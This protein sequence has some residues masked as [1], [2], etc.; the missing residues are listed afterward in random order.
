VGAQG[1]GKTAFNLQLSNETFP[2]TYIPT[3]GVDFRI[4]YVK[5]GTKINKVAIWETSGQPRFETITTS[6]FRGAKLFIIM[7]D[8]TDLE[9]FHKVKHYFELIEKFAQ[10]DD[11]IVAM[12][13][14]KLDKEEEK[15]V[16]KEDG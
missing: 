6:Y 4:K 3:I 1:T 7:Y 16:P 10:K 14:S 13:A 8:L 15:K 5:F 11:I 12:V 9:S 2:E